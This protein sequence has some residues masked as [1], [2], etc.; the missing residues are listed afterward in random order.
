MKTRRLLFSF[1]LC[2][3]IAIIL[4]V[5]FAVLHISTLENFEAALVFE[6]I[7]FALWFYLIFSA[8]IK[9]GFLVPII[10]ITAVYT[11]ALDVLSI[12]FVANLAPALFVTLN[13]VSLFI[14][15]IIV[16]PMYAMG[17]RQ[18]GRNRSW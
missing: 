1:I 7:G 2:F 12:V 16:F 15:C 13:L 8:P 9:T 6:G 18:N 10:C 5:F 4:H 14:Y 3:Y 11:I 17:R